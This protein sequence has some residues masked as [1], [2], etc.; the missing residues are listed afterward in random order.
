MPSSIAISNNRARLMQARSILKTFRSKRRGYLLSQKPKHQ[1]WARSW[2]EHP[3]Q[4]TAPTIACSKLSRLWP[5]FRAKCPTAHGLGFQPQSWYLVPRAASS[6]GGPRP[7]AFRL[8]FRG[9]EVCRAIGSSQ[10]FP[11][12]NAA[13]SIQLS[14]QCIGWEQVAAYII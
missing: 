1:R 10:P 14:A 4:I 11:E 3:Q 6:C 9:L 13:C 7:S 5:T 12:Q 2:P 8:I